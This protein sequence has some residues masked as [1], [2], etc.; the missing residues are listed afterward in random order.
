MLIDQSGAKDIAAE[1]I[2]KYSLKITPKDFINKISDI[3]N[4]ISETDEYLDADYYNEYNEKLNEQYK[5]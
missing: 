1:I 5:R 3:K 2:N 4:G